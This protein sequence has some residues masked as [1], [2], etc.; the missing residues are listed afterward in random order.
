VETA[1]VSTSAAAPW[2]LGR[3][4]DRFAGRVAL[5]TGAG[6]AGIGSAVAQRLAS[7]GASILALESHVGRTAGIVD[8]LES[9]YDVPVLGLTV[10][11]ADR[12]AV[13]DALHRGSALGPVDILVNN[14]A[15]NTQGSIF[16]YD[17]DVFDSVLGVDLTAAWYLIRRT[18]GAMREL[19]RGSIVNVSSVAAY[20]GGRGREGPYSAAKA[21]LHEVTRSVAIE[22]GPF[23][24]RCNAVAPGII[25]SRFLD[26][27]RER[28]EVEL[29]ATPLR[30]FGDPEDIANVVAFLVSDESSFITGEVITVSGGWYLHP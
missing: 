16:D 2:R 29:Q 15:I 22:A 3:T 28:F 6:G 19:G 26:K 12:A 23:G 21:G 8:A 13:D 30:R 7:E 10:D 11:V 14:A 20:N 27:H 18:I 17:P 24:I 1:E 4:S 5:V 25:N 9:T